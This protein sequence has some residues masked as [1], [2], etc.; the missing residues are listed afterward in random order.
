[1][2]LSFTAALG[3]QLT[4]SRDIAPIVWKKCSGCHRDQNIAPFELTSYELVKAR[5]SSIIEAVESG[6][7]PPW[8][9]DETYARHAF[10]RSLSSS[11]KA[12]LLEWLS[13]EMPEG[14]RDETP[15]LPPVTEDQIL[16][17]PDLVLKMPIPW[18]INGDGK[19]AFRLFV[20]PYE[21]A[22]DTMLRAIQFRPGN[23]SVVHHVRISLDTSG[24]ALEL[25]ARQAGQG[26]DGSIATPF[27]EVRQFM[28]WVPG[29][30][31]RDYPDGMGIQLF[32]KGAIVFNIHY[33]S[34]DLETDDQSSIALFYAKKPVVR[35][36]RP[37]VVS[38]LEFSV[39][40]NTILNLSDSIRA[41]EIPYD[42]SILGLAPHMHQLGRHVR[43]F[44]ITPTKDTIPLVD[45]PE[46][47]FHWQGF[48]RMKF[49]VMIPAMSRIIYQGSMDNTSAN[50]DNPNSPPADVRTGSGLRDEMFQCMLLA[51][52]YT[53]GDEKI[54]QDD[55]ANANL[56][57]SDLV[58]RDV[59][60][61]PN[62]V[63]DFLLLN[64][65]GETVLDL[66]VFSSLGEEVGVESIVVGESI[67]LDC[68]ELPAGVWFIRS[69]ECSLQTVFVKEAK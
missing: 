9:S 35:E 26:F 22:H 42:I 1:M 18:K 66:R 48:Y 40:A 34:S 13:G 44:A 53:F 29:M 36:I 24:A 45:V 39:K 27:P 31:T 55:Y 12:K 38:K 52:D 23:R 43:V 21:I 64:V 60:P 69:S 19:D 5:A 62:P 33:A 57:R 4:F 8:K 54:D 63:S 41:R 28:G 49:P 10:V 15:P 20:L 37:L 58:S 2:C 14:I 59:Q 11:D 25:D 50:K 68:R 16:G 61:T 56:V 30:I 51:V 7:M 46:W 3:Q 17:E 47:D 67:Q 65:P 32:K 6:E